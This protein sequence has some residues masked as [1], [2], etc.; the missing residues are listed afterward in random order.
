MVGART[1]YTDSAS[2]GK[3]VFVGMVT[4]PELLL[5]LRCHETLLR[6]LGFGGL[7]HTLAHLSTLAVDFGLFG[8]LRL[9][10]VDIGN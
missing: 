9:E 4:Y 6:L 10:T 8:L 3:G 1:E 5:P 7:L 2:L